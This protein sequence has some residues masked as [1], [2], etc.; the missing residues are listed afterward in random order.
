M[1]IRLRGER[2]LELVERNPGKR[3]RGTRWCRLNN[4]TASTRKVKIHC[5][6]VN[7]IEETK[8]L[9]AEVTRFNVHWI[10]DRH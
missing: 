2:K 3:V 5:I 6:T 7:K 8:A 10:V 4:I 1:R 9:Y